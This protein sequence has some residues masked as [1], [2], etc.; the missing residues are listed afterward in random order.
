MKIT[1][2]L[3]AVIGRRHI[4]CRVQFDRTAGANWK[5][6]LIS[7]RNLSRIPGF[8]AITITPDQFD[9]VFTD[10]TDS[11]ANARRALNLFNVG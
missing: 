1:T 2:G 4:L 11:A 10:C 3:I 6:T 9:S 5:A 8:P 7:G